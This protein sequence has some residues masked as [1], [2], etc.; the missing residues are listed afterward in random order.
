MNGL[1]FI[2]V[3]D[4]E[5]FWGHPNPWEEYFPPANSVR[6]GNFDP[7]NDPS[8]ALIKAVRERIAIEESS[9]NIDWTEICIVSDSQFG[10]DQEGGA[11]LLESLRKSGHNWKR[12]VIYSEDA[13]LNEYC[14]VLG[15]ENV[16]PVKKHS[17]AL[18][19]YR[20]KTYLE[21]S[22]LP[23]LGPLWDLWR[24]LD[25]LHVA[26]ESFEKVVNEGI[27]SITEMKSY[28]VPASVGVMCVFRPVFA[29]NFNKNH[30]LYSAATAEVFSTYTEEEFVENAKYS[31]SSQQM[32][33]SEALMKAASWWEKIR[34]VAHPYASLEITTEDRD[35]LEGGAIV[36]P[37][38]VLWEGIQSG[39]N[40]DILRSHINADIKVLSACERVWVRRRMGFLIQQFVSWR[41]DPSFLSQLVKR[42]YIT[43]EELNRI[44]RSVI[45]GE[46]KRPQTSL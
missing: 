18:D 34:Q 12:A 7:G 37:L 2:L 43:L 9:F 32:T 35:A 5:G 3:D 24:C 21:T 17:Q 33:G 30:T 25:P 46:A 28:G 8:E 4:Q 44:K 42:A 45:A 40:P 27:P 15:R 14:L 22:T 36:H 1:S 29:Q 19:A 11:R 6:V 10:M 39:V 23:S 13:R 31:I 26:L 16:L 38:R 20:I 41:G